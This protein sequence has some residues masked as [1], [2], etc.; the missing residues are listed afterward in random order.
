MHG[1]RVEAGVVTDYR[2]VA[3]TEWNFHPAGVFFRETLGLKATG[4]DAARSQVQCLALA[5][6]PCVAWDVADLEGEEAIRA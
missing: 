3:P 2:I 4:D 1:V 6:D 5:L